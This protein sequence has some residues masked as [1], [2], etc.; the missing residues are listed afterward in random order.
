MPGMSRSDESVAVGRIVGLRRYPVKSMG[1]EVLS[2]AE[3]SWHGVEGDRRW[4]FIREGAEQNGFPWL[5]LRQR[6]DMNQYRPSFVDPLQPDTSPTV[7]KTPSGTE[8]DVADPALGAELSEERV[9]VIRQGRGVFDAF[10]LSLITT[11]TVERLGEIV[12]DRLDVLRFRPNILVEAADD[13]PFLKDTWVGRVLR[14]GSVGMRVDKRD[15]RCS[16]ITLDP[17]TAERNPAFCV[18]WQRSERV[19]WGCMGRRWHQGGWLS[20]IWC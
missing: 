12:G 15:G 9:R 4:A 2:E 1:A 13:V 8:F 3:V 11:Q 16:V 18:R 5:T 6:G 19:A 7:V 20:A 17:E 10:P 14:F